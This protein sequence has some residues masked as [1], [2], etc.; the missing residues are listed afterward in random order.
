MEQLSA[1]EIASAVKGELIGPESAIVTSVTTNSKEVKKNSLFVP[2]KGEK[3]DAHDFIDEAFRNG[4][5]V[6][7]TEK[8]QIDNLQTG[9]Y[10]K[11]ENSICALQRLGEYY[12]SKFTIP[13]IGVTGSVGK[14][15]TKEMISCVLSEKFNVQKTNANFNGQI[16]VPLTV[17]NIDKKTEVAV[18]E[19][20]VSQFGEME[21]ISRIAK[22]NI[23]VINNIGISHIENF[24]TQ[25]NILTQKLHIADYLSKKDL[26]IINGDDKILSEFD[27]SNYNAVSFGMTKNCDCVASNIEIQNEHTKFLVKYKDLEMQVKIPVIG[28]HHVYNALASI[29]IAREACIDADVIKRG[30]MNFKVPSMRQ[31]VYKFGDVDIIDD[32]YNASP[33][34][35]KSAIDLLKI[36][37]KGKPSV[38]VLADML[39]L[40]EKAKDSHVEIGKYAAEN[41]VD[42][43][44]TVGELSKNMGLGVN[45]KVKVKSF[46]STK[47]AAEY[48]AE[49]F[50]SKC[51]I[52][53][54]GS[55]GMKMDY[56]VKYITDVLECKRND[57]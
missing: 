45:N 36:L 32:S 11:V 14:T 47:Q 21:R 12:R 53:I 50:L 43:L 57:K 41:D 23:C 9:T 18:I 49:N 35:M 19:M 52:L 44:I 48:I 1:K 15:S 28:L 4:A 2:I 5:S 29:I 20:G 31:Q 56:I 26:L 33:D 13:V 24:H 6:S 42:V 16:G 3:V 8:S 30:L 25:K 40:G 39:E 54:K 27:F 34:S 51:S 17:F 22:P 38:A 10:I 37:S 7:F 55:R 46:M